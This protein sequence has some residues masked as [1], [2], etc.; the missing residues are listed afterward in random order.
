MEHDTTLRPALRRIAPPPA[1]SHPA[2]AIA[3]PP[4]LIASESF[5][6]MLHEG[7]IRMSLFTVISIRPPEE[8]RP[9]SSQ[10]ALASTTKLIAAPDLRSEPDFMVRFEAAKI[11]MFSP[12]TSLARLETTM[13]PAVLR[14]SC[15]PDMMVLWTP[16]VIPAPVL[17]AAEL[18]ASMAA[19][20]AMSR[21]PAICRTRGD[22]DS[23]VAPF[24]RTIFSNR[25]GP[26][27]SRTEFAPSSKS[28]TNLCLT[29]SNTE[30]P[31][32]PDSEPPTF[33]LQKPLV[34]KKIEPATPASGQ[35]SEIRPPIAEKLMNDE[36]T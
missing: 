18:R 2:L 8:T 10:V 36:N 5:P 25:H 15:D 7:P 30:R 32:E 19:P 16:S 14:L 1:T 17:I 22:R 24:S 13:L 20:S 33:S 23:I 4:A 12:D 11:V 34:L 31:E 3:L 28:A 9:S 26:A 27:T 29:H 6:L 35:P 21:R